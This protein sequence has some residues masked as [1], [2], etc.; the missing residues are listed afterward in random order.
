MKLRLSLGDPLVE[1]WGVGFRVLVFWV[2]GF[3]V[4]VG[5]PFIEPQGLGF[6]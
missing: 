4:S 2:L 1:P 5:D 6:L 3:R